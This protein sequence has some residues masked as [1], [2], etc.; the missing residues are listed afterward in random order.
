MWFVPCP[1]LTEWI[2]LNEGVARTSTVKHISVQGLYPV[3]RLLTEGR[4]LAVMQE[5]L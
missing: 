2:H 1:C 4:S 3:L 5:M